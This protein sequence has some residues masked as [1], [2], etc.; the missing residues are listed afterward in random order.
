[1]PTATNSMEVMSEP[2][3]RVLGTRIGKVQILIEK[4]SLTVVLK[5]WQGL[6]V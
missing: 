4:D 5:G 3:I 6:K 2:V 1:M